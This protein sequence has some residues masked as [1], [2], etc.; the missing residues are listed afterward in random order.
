MTNAIRNL[1]DTS[2]DLSSAVADLLE[3]TAVATA[4]WEVLGDP[5]CF[6]G[7]DD[8]T[9]IAAWERDLHTAWMEEQW[10]AGYFD[11]VQKQM[12]NL[13]TQ[14]VSFLSSI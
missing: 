7:M 8:D 4:T 9:L 6:L 12:G 10:V 1:L 2:D 5:D 11:A 3:A 13:N 14:W